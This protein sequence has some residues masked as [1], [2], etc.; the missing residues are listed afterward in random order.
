MGTLF[1]VLQK[2]INN[3]SMNSF[4]GKIIQ[5]QNSGSI[6]MVD[7]EVEGHQF[8]AILIS[9][10][11]EYDWLK[12]GNPV[13]LIFKETEVSLAKGLSGK[14]SLRNRIPCK[15]ISV[16]KGLLLSRIEL[17]FNGYILTSVITT[18]SVESLDI[19]N[20]DEVEALVKANEMALMEIK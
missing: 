11:G 8:S 10:E 9:S 18:R 20:G 7:A 16:E 12:T 3:I 14:I 13:S 19:K 15:V 1:Q 6:T 4:K 17:Q 5:V 2:K